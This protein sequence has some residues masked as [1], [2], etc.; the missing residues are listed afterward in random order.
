MIKWIGV[1]I[2]KYINTRSM[3]CIENWSKISKNFKL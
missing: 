2:S 1:Q 3:G